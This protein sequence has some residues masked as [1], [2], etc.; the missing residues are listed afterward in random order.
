MISLSPFNREAILF[1]SATFNSTQDHAMFQ[2][3][4]HREV[5]WF[6]LGAAHLGAV[7][8]SVAVW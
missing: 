6:D 7:M 3:A 5:P 4:S 8:E 1:L 2:T